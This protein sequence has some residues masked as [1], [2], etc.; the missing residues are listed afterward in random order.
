MATDL[1]CA[2]ESAAGH[3]RPEVDDLTVAG[4]RAGAPDA[5]R[6]VYRVYGGLVFA[7]A[8]RVLGDR[9]LAEEASQQ[10]FVQAWRAAR[11]FDPGRDLGPWLAT[12]ARRAAID[13]HRREAVRAHRS[14]DE[15]G[16]HD[17]A[18][19]AVADGTDRAD[20]VRAVR[21]A[22]EDLPLEERDVVRLQHL[23]GLTHTQVAAHLGI[24]LGTVKSRSNRAHRRLAGRLG[25]LREDV[26]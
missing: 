2:H 5:V 25:H 26:G 13:L 14:L 24:P 3:D 4:F 19:L 11:S 8:L 21:S 20:Q 9:S 12:I 7:V 16:D 1:L 22:I 18:S 10:A 23:V 15:L 17:P 6:A